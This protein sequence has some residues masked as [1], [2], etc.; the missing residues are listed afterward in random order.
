MHK[1]L[2]SLANTNTIL[3]IFSLTSLAFLELE[4]C[5]PFVRKGDYE[6]LDVV[7]TYFHQNK[8]FFLERIEEIEGEWKKE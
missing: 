7:K 8:I 1:R 5:S 6:V 2:E 3:L 4:T